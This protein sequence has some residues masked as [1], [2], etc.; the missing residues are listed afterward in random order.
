MGQAFDGSTSGITV[1]NTASISVTNNFTVS[2]WMKLNATGQADVLEKGGA[3]GYTFWLDGTNMWFGPQ[4]AAPSSWAFNA[5]NFATGT[6]YKLDGVV[7]AGICSL[8]I[9]GTLVVS[10]SAS[11][12]YANAGALKIGNGIDGRLNG[13]IDELRVSN[14][15]SSAARIATE[16]R[17]QRAQH[18]L[19]CWLRDKL[20]RCGS[21]Q[22]RDDHRGR[23]RQ[24]R[25]SRLHADRRTGHRCGR[26]RPAGH[27]RD[28]T[29][30]QH[31]HLAVL[32]R[33]R[34]HLEQRGLGGG[35]RRPAAPLPG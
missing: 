25:R 17:N 14:T 15:V 34:Q 12:V 16:Y 5:A 26:Q 8:Y 22:F 24:R 30:Q 29:Q 6:W 23:D 32:D 19:R 21:Q 20:Q 35:K 2:V 33:Q 11:S 1:P 4:N 18:V 28:R 31:G 9:N 13:T 3:K 10:S 27:C 7:N